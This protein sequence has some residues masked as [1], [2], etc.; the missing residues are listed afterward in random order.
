L[1]NILEKDYKKR[2]SIKEA[3]EDPWI[4]GWNIINEE[5]ENTGILENF[6][7]E[8]ISDNIREFNMYIK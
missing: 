4:K 2:Y 7:I 6:I 5:K 8:L 3:L 1:K